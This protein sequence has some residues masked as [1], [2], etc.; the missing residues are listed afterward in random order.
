[1]EYLR[2]LHHCSSRA[3]VLQQRRLSFTGYE[4]SSDTASSGSYSANVTASQAKERLDK[5]D[6]ITVID[7]RTPDEYAAGHIPG[8]L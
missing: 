6:K 7:V 4:P 8:S 3:L 5:G 1:M 2:T